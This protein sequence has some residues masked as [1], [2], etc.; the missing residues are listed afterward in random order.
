MK[1]GSKELLQYTTAGG[2]P[3][4]VIYGIM[5]D[6]Y[7]RL[8]ISTN[9]GLSCLNPENGKFRN[10]TILDGLQGNQFNAGSYCRQDNG[11]MLFG[12]ST[13]LHYSVRKH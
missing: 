9:Q 11:Y 6:A 12:V 10:F 7:A 8:W 2:L 5:E 13:A 3:S 1:E 4:N